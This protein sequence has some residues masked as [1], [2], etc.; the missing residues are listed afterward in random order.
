MKQNKPEQTN[1]TTDDIFEIDID[2]HDFIIMYVPQTKEWLAIYDD[3]DEGE[4]VLIDLEK[5]NEWVTLELFN[6]F[7]LSRDEFNNMKEAYK[8]LTI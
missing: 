4:D 1:I 3:P 2:T 5:D 8:T 6:G 7:I